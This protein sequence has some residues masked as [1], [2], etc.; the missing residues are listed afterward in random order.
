MQHT[1]SANSLR[2]YVQGGPNRHSSSNFTYNNSDALTV[3]YTI[4]GT[5]LSASFD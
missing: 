3:E 2:D 1:I 5:T 4:S